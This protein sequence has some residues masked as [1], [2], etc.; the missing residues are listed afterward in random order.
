MVELNPYVTEELDLCQ[1]KTIGHVMPATI[2]PSLA[3]LV[4]LS[5]PFLA[6]ALHLLGADNDG[7]E[8]QEGG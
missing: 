8:E 3:T 2:R 5:V 7:E 1:K 6:W 4:D